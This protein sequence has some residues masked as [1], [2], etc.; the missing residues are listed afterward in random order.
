M[1]QRK[2]PFLL[3]ELLVGVS[4]LALFAGPLLANP[5]Y[6]FQTEVAALE[7]IELERISEVEFAKIKK[8]IY[9]QEISFE[10]LTQG[11]TLHEEVFISLPG[12]SKHRFE[13][14]TTFKSKATKKIPEKK[15]EFHLI[16]VRTSYTP[17]PRFKHSSKPIIFIY[18][19]L[20]KQMPKGVN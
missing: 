15:E 18:K 13:K 9:M 11:D 8:K 14:M 2:N 3:L 17:K 1:K 5:T 4:L 16:E 20:I 12:I 19:I 10:S 7:K 6:L